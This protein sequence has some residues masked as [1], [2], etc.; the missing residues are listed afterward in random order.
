[1]KKFFEHS[2]FANFILADGFSA[3]TLGPWAFNKGSYTQR[4][5]NHECT[6]MKQWAEWTVLTSIIITI[7][8][9]VFNISPWFML[10]CPI[11]YYILYILE[12]VVRLPIN[13]T[14]LAHYHLS[15]EYEAYNNAHNDNYVV[16]RNYFE[17]LKYLFVK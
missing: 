10:L 7:L 5:K 13:G 17:S 4:A 1:M 8:M 14:K 11:M 16:N 12:W 6:H 3:I 2:R 15:F 9:I